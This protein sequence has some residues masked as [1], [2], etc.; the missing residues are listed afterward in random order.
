MKAMRGTSLYSDPYLNQQNPFVLLIIVYTLSSTK[1]EI[2]TK[3]FLP[4]SKGGE[5]EKEG[6]REREEVAGTGDK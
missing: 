3:R 4:E 6:M 2:R 5:G 1:L